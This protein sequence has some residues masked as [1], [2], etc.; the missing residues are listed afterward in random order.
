MKLTKNMKS[1]FDEFLQEEG[2]Y[3]EVNDVAI[4]RVIAYQIAEEMKAQK[5]TKTKMAELMHT[6]RAVVN[7]LLNPDNDSLTLGTLES[8]TT[9]L[10]KRLNITIV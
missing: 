9:A 5:I 8:A 1:D 2:I 7:R 10:G 6:S 3:E 4:K